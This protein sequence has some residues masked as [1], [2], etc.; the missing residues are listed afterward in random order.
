M[1]KHQL[2]GFNFLA[3]NRDKSVNIIT[4]TKKE[5]EKELIV[6]CFNG[7]SYFRI[8][9]K[10][11][12]SKYPKF[13][14]LNDYQKQKVCD[15]CGYYPTSGEYG[16]IM[17]ALG[18]TIECDVE[19]YKMFAKEYGPSLSQKDIRTIVHSWVQDF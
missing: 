12:V 16:V 13:T 11:Y 10:F 19:T 17:G 18:I 14:S 15:Y 8:G 3:S 5:S 2:W 6:P 9:D 7:V 4:G 1:R